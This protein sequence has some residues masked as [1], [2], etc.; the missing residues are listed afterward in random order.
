ME[1]QGRPGALNSAIKKENIEQVKRLVLQN[2][3]I[4]V[5]M[6]S[7]V[8]DLSIGSVAAILAENLKLHKVCAK[9]VQILS[10]DRR[11]FRVECCTDFLEIIETDLDFLNK[12]VTCDESWVFTYDPENKR[13]SAQWKHATSPRPKEARMS[14]SQEKA[15]VIPFLDSQGIIHVGW[16]P[17]GQTVNKE[18]YLDVLRKFRESMR[19]KR[20]QQW[21]S[22]Q[23]WFHQD[24]APCHKSTLVTNW[25]TNRGMKVVWHPPYS[26]DLAPSDFFLFPGMKKPLRGI[27]FQSTEELK[28]SSESYLKGLQKKDFEVAFQDWKK[29]MQKCIAAECNYFEGDKIL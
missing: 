22:G 13:Q 18:Y 28:D 17:R 27:R 7:A 16:V 2:R 20:P 11:Q 5:R 15:M 12:V 1:D 26:P 25:M 29:R 19:K 4:S 24:N 23:W 3:R 8:V 6:I 10:D 14:R 21:R 9:F